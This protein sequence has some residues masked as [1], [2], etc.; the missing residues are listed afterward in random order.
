[1]NNSLTWLTAWVNSNESNISKIKF[2]CEGCPD[3]K[4]GIS[5]L[6]APPFMIPPLPPK[7]MRWEVTACS[8]LVQSLAGQDSSTRWAAHSFNSEPVASHPS[9]HATPPLIIREQSSPSPLPPVCVCVCV[10]LSHRV[11]LPVT[12][13][14]RRWNKLLPEWRGTLCHWTSYP[15]GAV[16]HK[17]FFL[18]FFRKS[19]KLHKIS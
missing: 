17:F 16:S 3:S 10:C 8:C 4:R 6:L 2:G 12:R 19:K 1:M 15:R 7:R 14:T 5:I 9:P 13:W 11:R 18:F